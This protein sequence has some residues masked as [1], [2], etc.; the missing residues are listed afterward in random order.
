MTQAPIA[1]PAS[2]QKTGILINRNFALLFVGQAI[3]L[4]GDFV[5]D[6]TL[7][8]WIATSI[9]KGQSY[10]PLAVSG[11]LIAAT[12]PIFLF[13]PIAGVFVDR[14]VKR[15][16]MLR[17]DAIRALLIASLLLIVPQGF[18]GEGQR[19]LLTVLLPGLGD[20][21]HHLPIATNLIIIYAL[22]F[23][24]NICS[25]FF[26]PARLALIGDIVTEEQRPQA[27]GLGQSLQGI[28]AI[29]GP[30]LA[31]PLLFTLGVQWALII[32]ALSFV[33]SFLA[34]RVVR[35]PA[36]PI[37][38]QNAT[39]QTFGSDF[40]AGIS[41][42]FGNR[43]LR[44]VL[45]IAA[46]ITLGGGGINAL[47]V[48]FVLQNLHT[49]PKFFGVVDSAVGVGIIA[50]SIAASFLVRPIGLTRALWLSGILVGIT[51]VIVSRVT[52]FALALPFFFIT[53][54]FEATLNTTVGPLVLGATPRE[55]VGRVV[56]VLNPLIS[57]TQLLSIALAGYLASAVLLNLHAQAFGFSFGPVD[58]ILAGAGG[59]AII[60]G[61]YAAFNLRRASEPPTAPA[62]TVANAPAA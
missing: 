46:I 50:G 24:V 30:P 21:Q 57:A 7:V 42:F 54:F 19:P 49:D 17:M 38:Q 56:S 41:Y 47:G 13:G 59:L 61:I 32:N 53:G 3:S 10:S 6:T 29:I 43:V 48:F 18:V 44:T 33:A 26:N 22:V 39:R 37:A 52:N 51:I 40:R 60:A 16:T 36:T 28:A 55:M 58:T 5:F 35:V 45:I 8:L 15:S 4:I 1:P 2:A 11:V 27:T 14:W 31:A 62:S 20:A 34:L 12:V 9:T 23:L 25:Q